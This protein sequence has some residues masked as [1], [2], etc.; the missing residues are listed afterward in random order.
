LNR[1]SQP[2]HDAEATRH[3]VTDACEW[4]NREL[5]E[6]IELM[7]GEDLE[8]PAEV[9]KIPFL[10]LKDAPCP[11][12]TADSPVFPQ[13]LTGQDARWEAA[14]VINAWRYLSNQDARAVQRLPGVLAAGVATLEQL[15]RVNE[16]KAELKLVLREYQ[17]GLAMELGPL[18][19]PDA[20]SKYA[21]L[22]QE[23]GTARHLHVLQATRQLHEIRSHMDTLS[24]YWS[25]ATI[26]T[27]TSL[28]EDIQADFEQAI[29]SGPPNVSPEDPNE[30]DARFRRY[31]EAIRTMPAHE[32]LVVRRPTAAAPVATAVPV[33]PGIQPFKASLPLFIPAEATWPSVFPLGHH[34]PGKASSRKPRSDRHVLEEP[35]IKDLHLYRY[36]PEHRDKLHARL[37]WEPSGGQV[38]LSITKGRW[39]KLR[40]SFPVA[41]LVAAVRDVLA[42]SQRWPLEGVQMRPA[43]KEGI[44]LTLD[45]K[46]VQRRVP[47][48]RRNATA[49]LASLTP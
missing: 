35:V 36:R 47:W 33:L 38:D 14:A 41:G 10:T 21:Q 49:L 32:E 3:A 19:V 9:F 37:E 1:E 26:I 12:H 30:W 28:V 40:L 22:R 39:M 43:G 11:K 42:G 45:M 48:S 6:L 20:G 23:S 5:G 18:Q 8:L 34:D 17:E 4:L 15:R 27:T 25:T 29:F 7:L 2:P 44:F 31:L 46:G 24:F 16:A 13:R